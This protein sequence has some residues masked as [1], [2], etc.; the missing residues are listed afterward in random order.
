MH[1]GKNCFSFIDQRNLNRKTRV[2]LTDEKVSVLKNMIQSLSSSKQIAAALTVSLRT[3]Q[4]WIARY[5]LNPEKDMMRPKRPSKDTSALVEELGAINAADQALTLSGIIDHLPVPLKCSPSTL[6]RTL[7]GMNYSRKRLKPIVADRNFDRVISERV[8]YSIRLQPIQDEKLVFIDESGFNLHTSPAYGYA[9]IGATPWISVPTQR[10][11][12]IS[13]IAAIASSGI[14]AH[15][16]IVGAYN[17][18]NMHEWCQSR[19]LPAL[20]TQNCIFILDNARFHH[21]QLITDILSTNGSR[22][23]FLPPYSPQLNPIE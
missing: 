2:E 5:E 18:V 1:A 14:V 12:N 6:C 23:L 7:K 22:V 8:S 4:R 10:R 20:R 21:A 16:T 11:R 17:T 19:L 13:L 15:Q 3:A 9:P